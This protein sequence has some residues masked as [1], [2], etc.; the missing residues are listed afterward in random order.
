MLTIEEQISLANLNQTQLVE[1]ETVRHE[2]LMAERRLQARVE[3]VRFAKE[4]LVENNRTKPVNERDVTAEDI[5]AL[6]DT[7]VNYMTA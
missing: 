6:A 3:A 2:N 4:T 7:L 5:T 1:L